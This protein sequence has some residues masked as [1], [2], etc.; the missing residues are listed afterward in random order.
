LQEPEKKER[1][2]RGGFRNAMQKGKARRG[3][4]NLLNFA[5]YNSSTQS[6][7]EGSLN[8]IVAKTT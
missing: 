2:G 1:R 4:R 6:Y 5:C 8:K 7:A 3:R